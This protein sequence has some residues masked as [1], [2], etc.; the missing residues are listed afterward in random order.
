MF[1]DSD[2]SD[3]KGMNCYSIEE[4]RRLNERG[5]IVDDQGGTTDTTIR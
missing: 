5:M 1:V 3:L 2:Y 4:Y